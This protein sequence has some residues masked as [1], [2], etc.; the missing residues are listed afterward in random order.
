M[1][2]KVPS[3]LTYEIISYFP[4]NF[5]SKK[6]NEPFIKNIM[7]VALKL[8]DGTWREGNSDIFEPDYFYNNIPL[9][10]TIASDKH[11]IERL[12]FGSFSTENKEQSAIKQ[13]T[14]SIEKK[15]EKKYSVT[16]VYLCVL[17][18]LDMT[19]WVL[20]EY[21]SCTYFLLDGTRENFF[22]EIKTK[23]VD[24]GIFKDIFLI[25]PDMTSSWWV[26]SI[27]EDQRTEILLTVDNIKNKDVPYVIEKSAYNKMI[28]E[29]NL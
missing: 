14:T 9:E 13:I 19:S 29:N 21:G 26:W 11:F 8:P 4:A 20:D 1:S 10:F 3:P 27:D 15:T 25:F 28:E 6:V 18:L 16:P 23:Y 2:D 17:C 24:T 12:R 22:K 5:F 7:N